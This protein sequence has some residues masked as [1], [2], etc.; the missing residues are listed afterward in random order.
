MVWK[1]SNKIDKVEVK[2]DKGNKENNKITYT[3]DKE[4]KEIKLL[5]N[6]IYIH[7]H[8]KKFK[9]EDVDTYNKYKDCKKGINAAG[10][11]RK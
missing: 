5:E 8:R 9:E 7:Y 11:L 1:G 3:K 6:E 4:E 10:V 2:V